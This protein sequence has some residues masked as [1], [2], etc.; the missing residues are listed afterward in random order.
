MFSI[1]IL[2]YVVA[3]PTGNW[4][5]AFVAGLPISFGTM[6]A[7]GCAIAVK[8]F[9]RNQTAASPET[10]IFSIV[11][12]IAKTIVPT[13]K[14]LPKPKLHRP[15]PSR[16]QRSLISE[17][18]FKAK[19]AMKGSKGSM[20]NAVASKL[21]AESDPQTLKFVFFFIDYNCKDQ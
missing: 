14:S 7:M 5:F 6:G 17:D 2:N 19:N 11:S 20:I 8:F 9:K 3:R 4:F 12:T 15:I 1:M 16:L 21:L 13:I 10:L 18:D